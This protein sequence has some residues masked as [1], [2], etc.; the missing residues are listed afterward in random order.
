MIYMTNHV[1]DQ[2]SVFPVGRS[3]VG[4]TEPFCTRTML[5]IALVCSLWYGRDFRYV[6]VGVLIRV[7]T[8]QISA[9]KRT[10]LVRY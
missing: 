5:A 6:Q 9:E 3:S 4:M 10:T 7:V 8:Y 2:Y 1:C